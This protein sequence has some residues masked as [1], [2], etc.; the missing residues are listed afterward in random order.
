MCL[1]HPATTASTASTAS[2]PVAVDAISMP[3]ATCQG[4]TTRLRRK[5]WELEGRMHCPVIGTCLTNIELRNLANKHG[6]GHGKGRSDYWLHTFFVTNCQHKNPLAL[7]TFKFLERKYSA[8]VRQF[9]SAK[10]S[11]DL[12]QLWQQALD[13]G[14]T[15]AALWATVSHGQCNEQLQEQAYETIHM[16][17]HQIGAGQQADLKRLVIAEAELKQLKTESQQQHK[18]LQQQLLDKDQQLQ[19][20]KTQLEQL[21]LANLQLQQAPQVECDEIEPLRQ[22]NQQLQQRFEDS[23]SALQRTAEQRDHWQMTALT[24]QRKLDKIRAQHDQDMRTLE[25]A[26][27]TRASA[28]GCSDCGSADCT[29]CPDLCTNKVL[30]VGGLHRMVEQYRAVV[31]R[32]NGQFS[33]HDGGKEDSRARLESMLA[34][35]DVIIC[36][37]DCVS[38]DAYYKLKRFCKQQNKRHIFMESSSLSSFASTVNTLAVK[39]EQESSAA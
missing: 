19:A 37:V 29:S 34:A 16:L 12:R 17:S 39:L 4:S 33:H 8:T 9:A 24:H 23:Q 20:L 18:K 31:E 28:S 11:E 26:F 15:A 7:A 5:L 27:G 21:Q 22:Q 1:A 14:E 36:A 13:R 3:L 25:A 6:N 32:S 10:S 38:H 30:L 2:N 35:A